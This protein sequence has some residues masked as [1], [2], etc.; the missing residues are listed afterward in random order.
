[1]NPQALPK[2][3]RRALAMG[4]V[5]AALGLAAVVALLP[6]MHAATVGQELVAG[7]EQLALEERLRKAPGAKAKSIRR[8]VLV[9]GATDGV[10][11]AELQRRVSELARASALTPRSTQI[12]APKREADLTAVS[13]DTSLQGTIEG[14]RSLLHTIET[15]DPLLFVEGLSI[16][17]IVAPQAQQ[18]PVSLEIKLKV[19]GYAVTNKVN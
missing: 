18:R 5:V 17:T 2:T 7:R 9:P 16:R 4:L 8:E 19:R 14:V 15:G 12:A 1:M 3:W 6:I 13:V 10:A 11:G